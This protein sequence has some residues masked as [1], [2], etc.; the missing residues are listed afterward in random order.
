VQRLQTVPIRW[1]VAAVTLAGV[2][3][4]A[5][6]ATVEPKLTALALACALFVAAKGLVWLVLLRRQRQALRRHGFRW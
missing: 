6:L 3:A 2:V 4:F 5:L 1:V